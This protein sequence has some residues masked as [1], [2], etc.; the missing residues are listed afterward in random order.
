MSRAEKLHNAAQDVTGE[1]SRVTHDIATSGEPAASNTTSDLTEIDLV[2]TQ[3][4][5]MSTLIG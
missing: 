5:D 4:I 3:P 1:R 2:S